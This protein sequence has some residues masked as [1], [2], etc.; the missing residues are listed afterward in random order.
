MFPLK[1]QVC[2]AAEPVAT[3]VLDT[4]LKEKILGRLSNPV[5]VFLASSLTKPVNSS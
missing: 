1:D 2:P 3:G 4:K 5:F